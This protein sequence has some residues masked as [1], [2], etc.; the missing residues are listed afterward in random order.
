MVNLINQFFQIGRSQDLET[1]LVKN[2]GF[3]LFFREYTRVAGN[4]II[5]VGLS[6]G[7]G[8]VALGTGESIQ[9]K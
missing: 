6:I 1:D 9:V 4:L 8:A 5:G 3:Q 2:E 7:A